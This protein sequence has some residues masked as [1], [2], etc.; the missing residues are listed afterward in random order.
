MELPSVRFH[1]ADIDM[2]KKSP[3]QVADNIVRG[4]E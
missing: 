4:I 3:D 1:L 2:D